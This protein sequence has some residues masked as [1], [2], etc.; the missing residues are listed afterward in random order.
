MSDTYTVLRPKF[1]IQDGASD[2]EKMAEFF[3]QGADHV[4]VVDSHGCYLG[5]AASRGKS[6]FVYEENHGWKITYCYLPPVVTEFPICQENSDSLCRLL[7]ER[8]Q[9]TA[10]GEEVPLTDRGGHLLR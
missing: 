6:R 4:Y 1:I 2:I 5:R 7:K 10:Y 8:F 9:Q 3:Q